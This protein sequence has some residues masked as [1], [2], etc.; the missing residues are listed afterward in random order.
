MAAMSE[1][2]DPVKI[3][4]PATLTKA[5]AKESK[6]W[7]PEWI[8]GRENAIKEIMDRYRT[9]AGRARKLLNEVHYSGEVEY[10]N[11]EEEAVKLMR[12]CHKITARRAWKLLKDVD[13]DRD[14]AWKRDELW[15]YLDS[16]LQQPKP[17][18]KLAGQDKRTRAQDKRDWAKKAIAELWGE[19]VPDEIELPPKSFYD[20]VIEH[21]KAYCKAREIRWPGLSE[22][23]VSR[24]RRG[25]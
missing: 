13:P 22:K 14:Y 10:R 15:E 6:Q 7:R 20:Q 16:L 2:I 19:D 3:T 5:Q 1:V 25:E 12:D 9:T 4:G 8:V 11:D 21:L 23:T 17:D 24:A 18:A